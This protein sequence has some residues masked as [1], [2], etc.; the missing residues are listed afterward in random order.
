MDLCDTVV[1]MR[2]LGILGC[3]RGKHT[4]ECPVLTTAL[5]ECLSHPRNFGI[6]LETQTDPRQQRLPFQR[7]RFC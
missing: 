3:E 7:S 4:T 6:F 5:H 1:E 2:G